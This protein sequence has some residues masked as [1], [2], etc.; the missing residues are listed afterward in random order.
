MSFL[1]STLCLCYVKI[2]FI[3]TGFSFSIVHAKT[4]LFFRLDFLSE[5]GVELSVI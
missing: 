2:S 5:D 4:V 3:D 1:F